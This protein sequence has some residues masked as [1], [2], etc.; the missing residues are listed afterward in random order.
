MRVED[1]LKKK[2]FDQNIALISDQRQLTYQQWYEAAERIARIIN[3]TKMPTRG[4]VVF[5]PN[6]INYAVAY[7]GALISGGFVLPIDPQVRSEE[8]LRILEYAPVR[9]VLTEKKYS[10]FVM[11][12]LQR[13][14]MATAVIYVDEEKFEI[15]HSS[16]INNTNLENTPCDLAL[17]LRT[18]GTSANPKFVMLS[19]QNILSNIEANVEALQIDKKDK[20]LITL[21]MYFSYCNTA[22]FLSHAYCGATIVIMNGLFFPKTFLSLLS[23]ERIT[24]VF[25]VPSVIASLVSYRYIHGCD[26]TSLRIVC[27]GGDK[28]PVP[29][30]KEAL[31]CMRD[32]QFVITY[33]LTE[34]SPRVASLYVDRHRPEKFSS[35]GKALPGVEIRISNPDAEGIGEVVVRGDSV[36]LGYYKR[37][38]ETEEKI[39]NGWLHTGDLGYFDVDGDLF[40]VGRK[41]NMIITNGINLFP[42]EIEGVIIQHPAVKE[43]QVFGEQDEWSGQILVANIVSVNG[44]PIDNLYK[45]CVEKLDKRKIPKRFIYVEGIPKTINGKIMRR[46]CNQ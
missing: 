41:G 8:F 16:E 28:M 20:T 29:L 21:P 3:Q 9:I 31:G 38:K 40:L 2:Q 11:Q 44:L 32:V 33:G 5:L 14:D 6:S 36:M 18:S 39:H 46:N 45:F 17:M 15:V 34:A 24:T 35:V 42:E 37:Q 43:V 26:L 22:Q 1:I 10:D 23:R 4:I 30:L 13:S 27:V 12:T 25:T 19:H 7:F